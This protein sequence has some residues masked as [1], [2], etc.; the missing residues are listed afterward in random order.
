[1]P[2]P[3]PFGPL[4]VVFLTTYDDDISVNFTPPLLCIVCPVI[5]TLLWPA[6]TFDLVKVTVS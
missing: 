3:K 6:N 2:T 1:M 4:P 5:V